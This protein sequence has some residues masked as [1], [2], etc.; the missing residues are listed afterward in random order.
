MLEKSPVFCLLVG[1]LSKMTLFWSYV[2][3][4]ILIC[5]YNQNDS[6]ISC[7]GF[8]IKTTFLKFRPSPCSNN[9]ASGPPKCCQCDAEVRTSVRFAVPTSTTCI[10]ATAG[11][12]SYFLISLIFQGKGVPGYTWPNDPPRLY[13]VVRIIEYLQT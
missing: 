13:Y 4:L 12:L 5:F 3:I 8:C 6:L 1:T 10:A 7:T 2:K 11:G 9:S